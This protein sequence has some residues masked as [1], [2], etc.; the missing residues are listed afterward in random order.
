MTQ[1][2]IINRISVSAVYAIKVKNILVTLYITVSMIYI[3]HNL[4]KN[5]C[6]DLLKKNQWRLLVLKSMPQCKLTT[7]VINALA[8]VTD[9][10]CLW[11][12]HNEV[13]SKVI[14]SIITSAAEVISTLHKERNLTVMKMILNRNNWRSSWR[15]L[16]AIIQHW[17]SRPLQQG[18]QRLEINILNDPVWASG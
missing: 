18:R 11:I 14:H 6:S 8:I 17:I 1:Q 4:Y 10:K 9:A 12:M 13:I 15:C 5:I 2:N 7:N 3:I 16:T